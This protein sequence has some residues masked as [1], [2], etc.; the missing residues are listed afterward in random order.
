MVWFCAHSLFRYDFVPISISTICSFVSQDESIC[1][2]ANRK[3]LA[4]THSHPHLPANPL[5]YQ[6]VSHPVHPCQPPHLCVGRSRRRDV[7]VMGMEKCSIYIFPRMLNDKNNNNRRRTRTMQ[8]Q[9]SSKSAVK[10]AKNLYVRVFCASIWKSLQSG[11]EF[12]DGYAVVA[13]RDAQGSNFSQLTSSPFPL[14]ET[15]CLPVLWW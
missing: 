7:R 2:S 8:Q 9:S 13:S 10:C 4:Y 12:V 3:T 11:H 6:W 15:P 5:I 14:V 1:I